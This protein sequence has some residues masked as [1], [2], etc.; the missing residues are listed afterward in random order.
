MA[1]FLIKNGRV[2]DGERFLLTDVLTDADRIAAV[3]PGIMEEANFV[4]D[5]AGKTVSPGLVDLHVHMKGISI[6]RY[7]APADMSCLPF[8]VTA[9]NDAGGSCGDRSVLDSLMVKNTVF[10]CPTLQDN[11]ADF[12]VSEE[13]LERY[14]DKAIGIKLYFDASDQPVRDITPVRE[15][16]R[17][18]R[19]RGLKVMVHC[20]DSPTPMVDIVDALT[21]GD[22]LTHA[23]HGGENTCMADDFAAL[24][25]AKEKGVVLDTGFAGHIHTDF[26]CFAAAVEAGWLPDT[27]ST[28]LTC[29][30]VYRRGGNYGLP[31]CMSLAAHAGMSEEQIMTAVTSAPAKALGKADCWG[32]L[33]EGRTADL[34]VLEYADESFSMTD[35]RG[36]TV[37][38]DA[39]YRCVLTLADGCLVYRR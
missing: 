32:Y 20:S 22:I 21:P 37:C 18:A 3:R 30:S 10:V 29:G 23:F 24:R 6:P 28:D 5:A 25:L 19:S 11:H 16:C 7:G 9:A 8:G 34:A 17:F 27:I 31:L 2:W 39:G 12:A 38:G 1:K 13:Q 26:G 14:G 35:E 36:N 33:K 15:V 4:F